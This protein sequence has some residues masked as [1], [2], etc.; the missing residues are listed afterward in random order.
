VWPLSFF[1]RSAV[2]LTLLFSVL[3]CSLSYVKLTS[4]F[5]FNR[6]L[7]TIDLINWTNFLV[8]CSLFKSLMKDLRFSFC[9]GVVLVVVV[10]VVAAAVCGGGV[11]VGVGVV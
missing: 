2:E 4:F 6:F 10:V 1:H 5:F 8:R 7:Y 3:L 11:G 9:G